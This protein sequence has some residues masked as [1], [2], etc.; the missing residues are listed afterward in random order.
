MISGA[1]GATFS[2]M[3]N[4]LRQIRE[5]AET[6]LKLYDL[7]EEGDAMLRE[8]IADT[9]ACDEQLDALRRAI[10]FSPSEPLKAV[11]AKPVRSTHAKNPRQKHRHLRAA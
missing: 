11:K 2:H 5:R 1:G 8:I 3:K 7:E 6:L 9:E 4:R 10:P